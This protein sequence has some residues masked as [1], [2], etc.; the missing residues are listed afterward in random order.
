MKRSYPGGRLVYYD[1]GMMERVDVAVK[2][3]FVDLVF[4][5]YENLPVEACDALEVMGTLLF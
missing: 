2:K 5:I 3:G 4:A 1:F